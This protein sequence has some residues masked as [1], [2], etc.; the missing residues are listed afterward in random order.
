MNHG[1]CGTCNL[2]QL[3]CQCC[4]KEKKLLDTYLARLKSYEC[5]LLPYIKAHSLNGASEK[6]PITLY[7]G[8]TGN[9]AVTGKGNG[10]ENKPYP[11]VS[12]ARTGYAS[13][14]KLRVTGFIGCCCVPKTAAVDL[15]CTQDCYPIP[16]PGTYLSEYVYNETGFSAAYLSG[17]SLI[18]GKPDNTTLTSTYGAAK[19]AYLIVKEAVKFYSNI[20][21]GLN[22]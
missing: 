8:Q 18:V 3:S 7:H 10:D 14:P 12:L 2:D 11:F 16:A 15:L 19:G 17:M 1:D 21:C 22:C 20:K 6:T 5:Y 9:I 4:C 13:T